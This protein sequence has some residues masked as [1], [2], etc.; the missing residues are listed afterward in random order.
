[1]DGRRRHQGRLHGETDPVGYVG[2][3]D[4]TSVFDLQATIMHCLGFN[5]EE[6]TYPFQGRN[7]RLTDTSGKV[8][9]F[10]FVL[11]MP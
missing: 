10:G 3:K 7:F 4:R 9:P 6:F 2:I 5:H 8:Y 11:M 1:L